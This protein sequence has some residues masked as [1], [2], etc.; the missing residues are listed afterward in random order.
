L[1]GDADPVGEAGSLAEGLGVGEALLTGAGG[2][3]GVGVADA[4][5]VVAGAG[6]V[7]DAVASME[8]CVF[9][10]AVFA[11]FEDL[12][13]VSTRA[14]TTTTRRAA[15]RMVEFK[16]TEPGRASV[17]DYVGTTASRFGP[18]TRG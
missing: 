9:G 14:G 17:V 3:S 18:L 10:S 13:P 8:T 11:L 2:G 6:A 12:Q 4:G 7:D 15:F 5:V 16:T 1:V